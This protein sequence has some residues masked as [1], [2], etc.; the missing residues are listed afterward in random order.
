MNK[1][2]EGGALTR[3]ARPAFST[4]QPLV[5][6]VTIVLN[7]GNYLEKTI[8]S[9][10]GQSYNNIEYIIIDGGSTDDTV[11]IVRK[12]DDRI[13]YWLSEPDKGI[14]DA[15][16]K[17]TEL[18]SGEWINFMN[19]GD[20]FYDNN[21]VNTV[22]SQECGRYDLIYGNHEVSYNERYSKLRKAGDEESMWKGMN[23][24]HQSTFIRTS[25]VSGNGFNIENALGADF[26]M[27]FRLQK[28]GSNF[29]HLD[30]T[31]ATI[32]AGGL[33]DTERLQ[34][35]RSHWKVVSAY[36]VSLKVTLYYLWKIADSVVRNTVK[37]TLPQG[38]IDR[39][40]NLK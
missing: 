19:A 26:E 10:I 15:M 8:Q 28:N 4:S 18:A 11:D 21:V 17:G 31:I 6:V 37:K 38:I 13:D 36:G 23:F 24:S 32:Q 35:I 1:R 2:C 40:T 29:S 33:T 27:I 25:L 9:V 5:T 7:G 22:F 30:K 3:K 14:Y 20:R 34:S 12:Y 39:I 16:N